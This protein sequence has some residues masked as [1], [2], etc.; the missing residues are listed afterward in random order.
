[1][2]RRTGRIASPWRR[3]RWAPAV[4]ALA[5][6]A[7]LGPSSCD[8]PV[9]AGN[10]DVLTLGAYSV[11]REAL[12]EG[13]L[14]AFASEW[15]RATGRDVRFEESYN[16]SGAQAR[17]I[18]GGFDADVAVLSLEGDVDLI[19]QAGSLDKDWKQRPG[20]G[21]VTRSLVVI[22][23]RPGNPGRIAD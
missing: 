18:A 13:V 12:R 21:I 19:A 15:K 14:P 11:I 7:G 22:G 4:V 8:G 16:A 20:K 23:V 10:T 6:A 3:W 1:M 2:V 17:A 9:G 5:V